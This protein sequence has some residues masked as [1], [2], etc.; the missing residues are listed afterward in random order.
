MTM[1]IYESFLNK[2]SEEK[3]TII[4]PIYYQGKIYGSLT[5]KSEPWGGGYYPNDGSGGITVQ[6]GYLEW[7]KLWA[8]R[9]TLIKTPYVFPTGT[10]TL[11]MDF[12]NG[13]YAEG[14][15]TWSSDMTDN[16]NIILGC[17]DYKHLCKI[18][19]NT[20]NAPEGQFGSPNLSPRPTDWRDDYY[21]QV[22][23]NIKAIYVK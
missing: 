13:T 9:T 17:W 21:Y 1:A 14:G 12:T 8:S 6:N 7:K 16:F 15:F 3:E 20:Y 22:N 4:L 5:N 19:G 2:E 10:Y 18:G 23:N 11:H